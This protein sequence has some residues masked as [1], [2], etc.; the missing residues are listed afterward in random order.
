MGEV[1]FLVFVC[2]HVCHVMSDDGVK[3][4]RRDDRI[5]TS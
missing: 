5:V 1:C 3:R 4:M 2:S